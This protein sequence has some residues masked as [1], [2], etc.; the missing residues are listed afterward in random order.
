[1]FLAVAAD[2]GIPCSLSPERLPIE[3][4]GG[5]RSEGDGARTDDRDAAYG[6]G[7]TMTYASITVAPQLTMTDYRAVGDALGP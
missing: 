5:P 1:V 3:P 6:G 2:R 4:P 7:T